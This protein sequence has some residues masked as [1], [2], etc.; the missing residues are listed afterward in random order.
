MKVKVEDQLLD[1]L[2]RKLID[3]DMMVIRYFPFLLVMELM[4]LV[5]RVISLICMVEMLHLLAQRT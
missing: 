3:S 1:I 5:K 2:N 4:I